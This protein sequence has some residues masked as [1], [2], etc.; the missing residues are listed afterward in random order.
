MIAKCRFK[1]DHVAQQNVFVQQFFAPDGDRLEGQWAFAQAQ[2]HCIA[3]GLDPLGNGNLA[4]TAEQFNRSHFAQIHAHGV[5]GAIQLF[6]FARGNSNILG[7]CCDQISWAAVFVL[8]FIV[9][10]NVDA[11]F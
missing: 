7:A 6:C 10:D 5:I 9:F 2:D 1:V 3:P 4:L 8:D 11:H